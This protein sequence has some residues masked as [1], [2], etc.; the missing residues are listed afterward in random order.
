MLLSNI[1]AAAGKWDDVAIVRKLMKD[2]ALKK[3]PGCSWIEVGNCVHTF[4]VRDMSHPRTK[5]I[6]AKLE[7]LTGQ[8]EAAGYVPETNFVL[9]DLDVHRMGMGR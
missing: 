3:E 7:E 4:V 5:E 2:R 6:Y 1:F 8:M 9:H